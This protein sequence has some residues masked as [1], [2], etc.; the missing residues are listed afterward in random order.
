MDE[1]G[2]LPAWASVVLAVAVVLAAICLVLAVLGAIAALVKTVV[3]V[4]VA[5]G[6]I[7][8]ALNRKSEQGGPRRLSR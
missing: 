4:V 6:V 1:D 7:G 3:L 2:R 5:L 8:W